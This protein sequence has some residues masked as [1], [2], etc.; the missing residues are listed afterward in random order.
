MSS[1]A[2]RYVD[3]RPQPFD[4]LEFV[5]SL[6]DA[7]LI[8]GLGRIEL[9]VLFYALAMADADSAEVDLPQTWLS[10]QLQCTSRAVRDAIKALEQS[11]RVLR[12][13][14]WSPHHRVKRYQLT[15]AAAPVPGL[16]EATAASPSG[17][18]AA[19]APN[20]PPPC[21]RQGNAA[22]PQP[23]RT[24]RSD[25]NCASPKERKERNKG[26]S[27]PVRELRAGEVATSLW[28]RPTYDAAAARLLARIGISR[29]E[30]K[31]LVSHYRPTWRQVMVIIRNARARNWFARQG[32]AGAIEPVKSLAAFVRAAI[33]RGDYHQD[34]RVEAMRAERA[35]LLRGKRAQEQRDAKRETEASEAARLASAREQAEAMWERLSAEDRERLRVGVLSRMQKTQ[36]EL[37]RRW[38]GFDADHPRIRELV[39]EEFTEAAL[40]ELVDE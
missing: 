2:L 6:R 14:G 4:A 28:E 10:E 17:H 37:A 13:V 27:A 22:S 40:K 31:G 21:G 23:E 12:C 3:D 36:P 33:K 5:R 15:P 25:R 35:K 16:A 34:E 20:S 19:V 39:I 11:R 29:Q 24:F 18:G 9:G 7:E 30:S 1:S 38:A 32:G 26:G 8:G